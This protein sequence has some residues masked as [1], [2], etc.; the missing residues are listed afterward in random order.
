MFSIVPVIVIIGFAFVFGTIIMRSVQGAKQWQ[1]NN[2]SPV[3][4]VDATVVAK[5]GDTHT[6]H[7][8]TGMNNMH[9]DMSSSTT[10]YATFEV[11]SGDRIEF[12]VSDTEYGML[13][14]DD[15]GK[16]TFQGT[17]YLGFE[18]NRS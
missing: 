6:Y 18:R 14:E 7:H 15:M 10:Y 3:L 13:A 16:V 5:R 12:K 4:T 2:E 17:R 9:H 11:S 1:R 8:N